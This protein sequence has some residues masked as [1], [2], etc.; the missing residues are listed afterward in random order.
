MN[1]TAA[2]VT[3][4]GTTTR[5]FAQRLLAMGQTR[6]DLLLMKLHQER[7]KM[8]F[9]MVLALGAATFGLLAGV[10]LTVALIVVFWEQ[11][12]VLTS[13]ILFTLYGGA[14]AALFYRL[15]KLQRNWKALEC[16]LDQLQKDR[17]CLEQILR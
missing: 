3:D 15:V 12:P 13:F 17:E 14:G 10:A 4:L 7:D 2:P 6:L 8:I 5:R 9:A 11:S 1:A 16:T